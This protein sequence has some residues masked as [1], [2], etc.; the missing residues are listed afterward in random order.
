MDHELLYKPAPIFGEYLMAG[1]T[2]MS[3]LPSNSVAAMI[4]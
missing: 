4:S 2:V 3:E 1:I